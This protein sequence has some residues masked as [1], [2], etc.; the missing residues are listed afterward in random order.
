MD[1]E[2]DDF[3][4]DD[5]D[6]GDDDDDKNSQQQKQ[7]IDFG[8]MYDEL[9]DDIDDDDDD[10]DETWND[11]LTPKN[12]RH[13]YEVNAKN[14]ISDDK[15]ILDVGPQQIS[16]DTPIARS[17][18]LNADLL[19][20][21]QK[22]K[23]IL[24][25]LSTTT[26]NNNNNND[27]VMMTESVAEAAEQLLYRMVQE[28][29]KAA[30]EPD[31]FATLSQ[32][33][34]QDFLHV[35]QMWQAVA[36]VVAVGGA[37]APPQ[38]L[39]T[40]ALP[41]VI[42]R[43]IRLFRLQTKQQQ[44]QQQ[45]QQQ[46][47][48]DK[49]TAPS[50]E[51]YETVLRI[52]SASRDRGMDRIVWSIFE[53]VP[54]TMKNVNMYAMV[55]TSLAKSRNRGSAK[56]AE[57]IL[58]EAI[59]KFPPAISKNGQPTGITIDSFN[60]VLV[61]WA[62]SGL[63]YG[64][65]QAEKLIYL[66]DETDTIHGNLG[67]VRPNM[68]SFTSLI[69]AYAQ[70]GDWDGASQSERI[71]RRLLS[72]YLSSSSSGN[73]DEKKN[74]AT[75]LLPEP[76]VASWTIVISAWSRLSKKGF[77]RAASRAGKL[78][79][80][81][82]KLYAQGK[83]SSRPDA[84]VY[85]TC[86]NAHAFCKSPDG[87]VKAEQ[88]LD[89]TR[90][91]HEQGDESMKPSVK[92]IRMV[93]DSWMRSNSTD[94]MDEAELLLERYEE[95]LDDSSLD[96]KQQ[97][98]HHG[99]NRNKEGLPQRIDDV[100]DIY[101]NILFSWARKGRPDQAQRYLQIMMDKGMEPDSIHYDKI[102]EANTL[103]NNNDDDDELAFRRSYQ[104]FQLMEERRKAGQLQPNERAYTSF[105]RAMTKARVP[106]LAVKANVILRRMQDLAAPQH[107]QQEQ[108]HQQHQRDGTMALL[109]QPT[110]F[111][112]NAVL[113]ACA[114]SLWAPDS[115]RLEAFHIA[116]Q[117]FNQVRAEGPPDHVTYGNMLRC[118]QLLP[119]GDQKDRVIRSTFSLC[120]RA[121]FVN[122]FV[123]RDLHRSASEEL[124]H[125]LLGTAMT[126]PTVDMDLLP[127]EWQYRFDSRK[128]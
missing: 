79:D 39:N 9:D 64:P 116:L 93:M 7:A 94:A 41:G 62:K 25:S 71:L 112:Y 14:S 108:Q 29:N 57:N 86:M 92:S 69:D 20:H 49:A 40:N 98:Q 103:L 38:K 59:E 88:L 118:A 52:V 56:R 65:D 55:I 95:F 45:Q 119:D 67:L 42:D 114:E 107:Q 117:V 75:A 34:N 89:M 28:W 68:F 101:S 6:G 81:M 70:K 113:M 126:G 105:I 18:Y 87:P 22:L 77:R 128:R 109:L 97:Q 8:S 4:F 12:N 66:M 53:Q 1:G 16:E 124:W 99:N 90:E 32:P 27:E 24:K 127:H 121:G 43:V 48:L 23:D 91:L 50:E 104:V 60:V 54:K 46:E 110:V 76:S 51:T 36:G 10:D 13:A 35:Y 84:I 58:L 115:P 74:D 106:N 85:V 19:G 47:Q 100:K 3:N 30:R 96:P 82:E 83:I 37:N 111:S 63:P 11:D 5:D 33:T 61:A 44:Q 80:L 122:D 17:S 73:E 120:C 78:L 26:T 72:Q 31:P 125:S 2:F 123:I 102:I 15:E 21:E